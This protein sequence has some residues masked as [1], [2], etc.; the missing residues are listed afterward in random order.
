MPYFLIK[1][2]FRAA[3]ASVFAFIFFVALPALILAWAEERTY[4]TVELCA[5][6]RMI[7]IMATHR[8]VKILN[9]TWDRS[10]SITSTVFRL[11]RSHGLPDVF[12]GTLVF[13]SS[14]LS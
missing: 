10:V 4:A 13:S 6:G 14:S 7:G 3:I 1:R 5:L 8:R 9:V 11:T 12:A 2:N